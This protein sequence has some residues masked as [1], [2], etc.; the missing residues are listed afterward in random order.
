MNFA[1]QGS[2]VFS[3]RRVN[4]HFSA[5]VVALIS[6]AAVQTLA[7]GAPVAANAPTVNRAPQGGRVQSVVAKPGQPMQIPVRA[8]ATEPAPIDFFATVHGRQFGVTD[9]ANELTMDKQSSDSLGFRHTTFKQVYRGIPVFTGVLKV[10]QNAVGGVTAANGDF[11][12][13]PANFNVNPSVTSEVAIAL[14]RIHVSSANATATSK[15]M[16]VDPGWYGDAP[17]GARLVYYVELEDAA[18]ALHEAF[19]IDAQNSEVLDQWTLLETV[20]HREVWDHEGT[21]GP[22]VLSRS[23]GEASS[24]NSEVDM[25]YDYSGDTYDY[26]F[27]AFGRDSTNNAGLTLTA[28]VNST[29][30]PCPNATGGGGV[31]TFCTG[32]ATDDV[33]AHEFQHSITGFSASLIYQNQPGQLNEAMSDIFG[34][35][36]DMYNGDVSL[37][38]APGGT[39]WPMHDTGPGT[40]T[41]NN[42]RSQCSVP[43]GAIVTVNSPF[44]ANYFAGRAFFGPELTLTGVTSNVRAIEPAEACD[45]P[46]ITT[47]TMFG[48]STRMA[49]VNRGTCTFAEKVLNCQEL[50]AVGVIVVNNVPGAPG[51]N[52]TGS[53]PSITIPAVMV[54]MADGDAIRAA[55]MSGN[56]NV[57]IKDAPDGLLDG[58]RWLVSEDATAFGGA[59]RDM[60]DPTCKGHPD[61]ANSPLQTCGGMSMA[62]NGGVHSGSGVMNHTFAI[63]TDGKSYNGYTVT[64]VGPIKSGAVIYRALTEYMTA[65]T[66]FNEAYT[67]INLAAQDLVGTTP[68]DPRTG[69]SSGSMFTA[70]DAMEIDE[71]MLATEMNTEGACGAAADLLNSAPPTL[72]DPNSLLYSDS[73][74]GGVNGWTVANSNPPTPYDWVQTTDLPFGR[75]GTAWYCLDPDY[76]DCNENDESGV[77]YLMSPVINLPASLSETYVKFTHYMASEPE[78]DGGVVSFDDGGGTWVPFTSAYFTYNPYNT[79]INDF[80]VDGNTN[81]LAGLEGFTGAGGQWGTSLIRLTEFEGIPTPLTIQLRFEFGKDGCTG[82]D[83]WYIDDFQIVHCV[84]CVSDANCDDNYACTCDH[85]LVTE[86][87]VHACGHISSEYGNVDC[88]ANQQPSLD[89]ILC[90]LGGFANYANCPN[91]DLQPSCVGNNIIN[92]DDIL[93]TL[94]AFSGV[95]PCGCEP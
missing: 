3:G 18:I 53:D 67:L 51:S 23:E 72:C 73:F 6:F 45:S 79:T 20:R 16:I 68:N 19:F 46:P 26:F 74:E 91:A 64:G 13:I 25:A 89:D 43:P 83:G 35:L 34:E 94:A 66:D 24:G 30:P 5:R 27:R 85:C 14:A 47:P 15:L 17:R 56:V 8:G 80:I 44:A 81:P 93:A 84:D 90:A 75:A 57:T 12:K 78:W 86:L 40:D 31:A 87:G 28:L 2:I 70:A 37:P 9:P 49:L 38:G 65:A 22:G 77:H 1:N 76:G 41:P 4:M 11:Y 54:S 29:A 71:A 95:D 58:V 69:L 21:S 59:I 60:W 48:S 10:H 33:T 36:V 88:S 82:V 32:T 61:R 7:V 62:D 92:L 39:P 55:L 63:M 52:M 50:G 42:L